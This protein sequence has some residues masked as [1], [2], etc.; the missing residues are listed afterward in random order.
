MSRYD[1]M[2]AALCAQIDPRLFHSEGSGGYAK[3]RQI[4]ARCPVQ[5]EC[6]DH[7]TRLDAEA[8]DRHGMWA[9]RTR[10]Q[11]AAAQANAARQVL[12]TTVV[13]LLERGGM[14]PREIAAQV[15]CSERTV[16]RIQKTRREQ[17][18]AIR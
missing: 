18:E 14:L 4:C 3:A 10:G 17:T 8:P 2:A 5:P 16:L 7:I 1:W 6:A 9:G 15:G 11:R 13:R 12:H